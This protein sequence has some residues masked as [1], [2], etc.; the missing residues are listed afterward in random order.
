MAR[1]LN[2]LFFVALLGGVLLMKSQMKPRGIRNNNPGNLEN[3]GIDW[4][5]LSVVQ[6]DNRF[7]QFTKPEYG[8]RALA[9]VLKTYE[10]KYGLNTVEGIINRWAPPHENNTT[11]YQE[12]VA[13]VLG[14]TVNEHFQVSDNLVPLAEAI[15]IHENGSNPYSIEL[16]AEGVA[17][18]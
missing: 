9:R 16:V 15:I 12:H 1:P 10:S 4:V 3:N 5:G 6:D 14:V 11:S 17:L 13:S 7:Y 8:I 18:A 2:L